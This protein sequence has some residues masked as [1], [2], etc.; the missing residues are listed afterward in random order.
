MKNL[1]RRGALGMLAAG[2]GG[3]F[4]AR[5]AHATLLRGMTVPTLARSSRHIVAVTPLAAE[6]HWEVLGGRR[7]IVTD[8]R[9]RIDDVLAQEDPAD[10]E[11]MVRTLGG[12]IGDLGAIV[13]GEA[14]LTPQQPCVLFLMQK[15]DGPPRVTGLAQGHYPLRLDPKRSDAKVRLFGSPRLPELLG[16][17]ELAVKRLVGLQLGQARQLVREALKQ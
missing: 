17:E 14:E 8:T 4:Q 2:V 10:S 1:T 13:F 12:T 11:M 5:L 15:G 6:A 9:V 7:R 16:D 3:L